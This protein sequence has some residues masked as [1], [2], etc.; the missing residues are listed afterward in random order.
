M[1]ILKKLPQ[2][3]SLNLRRSTYMTDAGLACIKEMPNLQYLSLLYNNITNDGLA[4]LKGLSKLK[5]LDLRGCVQIS[6]A[7]SRTN[8]GSQDT[9][10]FEAS[11]HGRVG[12]RVG[13]FSKV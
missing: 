8:Q 4:Q 10:G 2:L 7:G 5:M 11:Q 9:E 1:K 6:D 13:A 3:K 12:R